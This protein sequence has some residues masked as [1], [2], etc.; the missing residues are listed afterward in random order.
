MK[1]LHISDLHIGK[2]IYEFTMLEEQKY[3]LGEILDI[4]DKCGVQAILISGDVYDKSVPPVEAVDVFDDFVTSLARRNLTVFVIAG[5]H[6]SP[7]RLSFG[8]R[9]M[10]K[11][12]IYFAGEC[13]DEISKIRLKDEHGALN[14]YLMPYLRPGLALL[15]LGALKAD[16]SE[17]NILLAH[18]F[19]T[20]EGEHPQLSDSESRQEHR[21]SLGGIGN[22]DAS[23]FDAFDYVALGH[24]HRPQKIGRDTVRYS[25]SPL[26]YSFSECTHKKSAVIIDAAEKGRLEFTLV[27]LKPKRD[28]AEIKCALAE[29]GAQTVPKD[30]YVHVTLTDEALIIDAI[31][32]VRE[33]YPDVMLLDYDN[34]RSRT[35]NSSNALSSGDIKNQT[36]LQLF[37]GFF[38]AQ[39]GSPL[40]VSQTMLFDKLTAGAE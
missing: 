23:L 13:K 32:K 17:R 26:K 20:S 24:I 16:A 25:G 14:I 4:I 2:R 10:D 28:L 33:I 22:I 1:L 19:V 3:I 15:A 29:L 21:L 9:I 30:A 12:K 40:T 31:G 35:E 27:E 38:E 8:S 34:F 36:P 6:D 7:E 37:A 39:N 18:Q 5:N 11:H